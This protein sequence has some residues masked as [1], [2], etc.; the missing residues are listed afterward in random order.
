MPDRFLTGNGLWCPQC[1][2]TGGGVEQ[3]GICRIP[4]RCTRCRGSGRIA[5]PIDKIIAEQ[6]AEAR[7]HHWLTEEQ[8]HD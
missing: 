1:D 4:R 3:I 6:I 8:T 7:R 5:R 2:G